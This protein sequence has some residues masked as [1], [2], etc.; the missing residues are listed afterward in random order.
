[1]SWNSTVGWAG[2]ACSGSHALARALG[3]LSPA[4]LPLS[5]VRPDPAGCRKQAALTD[6]G[7][8]QGLGAGAGWRPGKAAEPGLRKARVSAV[9]TGSQDPGTRVPWPPPSAKLRPGS[10][11]SEIFGQR[12]KFGLRKEDKRQAKHPSKGP[13]KQLL[14]ELGWRFLQWERGCFGH[15][16]NQCLRLLIAPL[17]ISSKQNVCA[18]ILPSSS[19]RNWSVEWKEGVGDS[20]DGEGAGPS[21]G[22]TNPVRPSDGESCRRTGIPNDFLLWWYSPSTQNNTL[23]PRQNGQPEILKRYISRRLSLIVSRLG[24]FRE[25]GRRAEAYPAARV[26][27]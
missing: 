19:P 8:R 21:K 2:W 20:N 3:A 6:E 4:A 18:R 23:H 22:L 25:R 15:W 14:L 11:N 27:F 13:R 24:D 16:E 7:R 9:R 12:G 1:M 26:C 5:G 17:K 10:Q